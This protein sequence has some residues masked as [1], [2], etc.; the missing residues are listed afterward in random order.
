[1]IKWFQKKARELLGIDYFESQV[2][3]IMKANTDSISN[4]RHQVKVKQN[5]C[6]ERIDYNDE[7]IRKL[8]QNIENIVYIGSDICYNKNERSWAVVCIEGKINIVKFVNLQSDDA[9]DVLHFLKNYEAGNHIIDS[10]CNNMF[11]DGLFKF[12][13]EDSE[14]NNS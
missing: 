9:Q 8:H 10:P 14:G 2:I 12:H 5:I 1:M 6:L 13:K 11:Y 7:C 3:K 4:L